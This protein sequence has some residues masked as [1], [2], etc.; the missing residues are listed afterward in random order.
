MSLL[1]N[2]DNRDSRET[3]DIAAAFREYMH[4]EREQAAEGLS[5]A[6]LQRWSELKDLLNRHFQPGLHEERV[7]QRT[8]VRL[9]SRLKVSFGSPQEAAGSLL[10]NVS[11]GGLFVATERPLAVGSALVLK[12]QLAP[13]RARVELPGE[14]V[15][16]GSGDP[17]DGPGMGIRFRHLSAEQQKIV[18][19]LY[20]GAAEKLLDV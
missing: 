11:R 9:P 16:H 10:T 3:E 13:E 14:V 6:E 1:A 5:V 20:Q 15:S 7:R 12:I 4:L 2:R 18:D 8:S 17:A 19:D